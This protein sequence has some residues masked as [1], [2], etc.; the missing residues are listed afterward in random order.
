MT[1]SIT[2]T[3]KINLWVLINFFGVAGYL[4]FSSWTWPRA[5]AEGMPGGPGDPIIWMLSALPCIAICAVLNVVWIIRISR[6]NDDLRLRSI[7]IWLIV[8]F[9]WICANRY[10]AYR[11]NVGH[12]GV[13]S[14]QS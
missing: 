12:L 13:N 10:D 4:L 6:K 5:D 3:S 1:S 2:K 14:V 11:S 9:A 8:I 7:V